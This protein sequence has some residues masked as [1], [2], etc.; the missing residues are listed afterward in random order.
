MTMKV[1]VLQTPS[2]SFGTVRIHALTIYIRLAERWGEG[3]GYY[4]MST[5]IAMVIL[6]Y[7]S[8]YILSIFLGDFGINS[9]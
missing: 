2:L 4:G 3:I 7:R 1:F 9:L 6:R 5:H 8:F